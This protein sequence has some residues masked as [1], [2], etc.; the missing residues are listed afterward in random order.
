VPPA[1]PPNH[2]SDPAEQIGLTQLATLN[3]YFDADETFQ[4]ATSPQTDSMVAATS[5]DRCIDLCRL[6]L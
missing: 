3:V 4:R 1:V 2:D 5:L 6:T